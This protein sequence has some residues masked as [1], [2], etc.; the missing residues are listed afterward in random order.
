MCVYI[1]VH[2]FL[3]LFTA[4]R[5][6]SYTSSVRKDLPTKEAVSCC[7]IFNFDGRSDLEGP[8][9]E[10]VWNYGTLSHSPNAFKRER[11]GIIY[12]CR[13]NTLCIR[14][15]CC[16]HSSYM[17]GLNP[18]GHSDWVSVEA[19]GVRPHA[20]SGP[21]MRSANRAGRGVAVSRWKP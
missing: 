17:A 1:Y 4:K 5:I 2:T 19:A 6:V 8:L 21:A 9:I 20:C 16:D 18:Q 10:P 3:Y 7:E 13:A 14:S 11:I 15:F 12:D